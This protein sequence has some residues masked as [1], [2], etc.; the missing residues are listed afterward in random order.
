L[1]SHGSLSFG[2]EKY[3]DK[4]PVNSGVVKFSWKDCIASDGLAI[5]N[6]LHYIKIEV[7]FTKDRNM[8]RIGLLS[9]NLID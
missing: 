8:D 2:A 7:N 1:E 9:Y 5:E 6:H 4:L 3:H